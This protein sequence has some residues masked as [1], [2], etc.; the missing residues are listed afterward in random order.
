MA[1]N[2]IIVSLSIYKHICK[3]FK[4][5]YSFKVQNIEIYATALVLYIVSFFITLLCFWLLRSQNKN[6]LILILK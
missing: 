1:L 4:C 5:R 2:K 6:I 3:H